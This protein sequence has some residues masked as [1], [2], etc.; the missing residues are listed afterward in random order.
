MHLEARTEGLVILSFISKSERDTDID[1]SNWSLSS[2]LSGVKSN[3]SEFEL[4]LEIYSESST[5]D[6]P[7]SKISTILGFAVSRLS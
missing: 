4:D 5:T 2:S 7:L 6:E 3:K 1:Y